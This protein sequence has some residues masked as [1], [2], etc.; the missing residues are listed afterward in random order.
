M[1]RSRES[2]ID[3]IKVFAC[4]LVTLGHFL[5]SM[6]KSAFIPATA[7]TSWFDD[8]IYFFHVPLFFI[9][10]GFVYQRYSRV[11]SFSDWKN[12]ILKKV[13]NLGIP[14]FT[15]SFI[16]WLLKI[17]FSGAVNT[18]SEG[19]LLTLLV[20]PVAPYWFLYALFLMF[21]FIPTFQGR[22]TMIVTMVVTV[23]WKLVFCWTGDLP[24][25]VLSCVM[26]NA[27]WF[28]GG[29]IMAKTNIVQKCCHRRKIVAG[30]TLMVLFLGLTVFFHGLRKTQLLVAFGMG[31]LACSAIILLMN[32]VFCRKKE[33]PIWNFLARYTMPVFLMH[34]IFAAGWRAVL[35]K[36]G[37]TNGAVHVVTGL[38]ISFVGPV[39]AAWIMGKVKF[40]DFFINP[41]RY[42][43]IGKKTTA[44]K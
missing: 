25:Y 36:L 13:I 20:K 26:G 24:V 29:M 40:L 37:V 10:S 5:Q 3:N 17:V 7:W 38:I 30:S 14:Y 15:F 31:V 43:R 35:V 27:V 21:L 8:T 33:H 22:K 12:H 42:I 19:L 4:I 18:E 2:W 1:S 16:T 23:I 28:V 32:G 9:C 6:T 39:I 34:T 11:C 44:A 41:G